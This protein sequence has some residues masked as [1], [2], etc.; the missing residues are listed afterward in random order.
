MANLKRKATTSLERPVL[1]GFAT[2]SK[3]ANGRV[4]IRFRWKRLLF[5]TF[6]MFVTGWITVAAALYAHFKYRGEFDEVS[7]SDMLVLPFTLNEHR[8]KMGNFQVDKGLEEI[9][10]GNVRD[11]LRLLRLGVVRSPG[12]LKGRIAIAEIFE[13]ALKRHDKSSQL[14]IEGLEHGGID[15]TDYL[16]TTIRLLLRHQ[17][18]KAIQD[19][20][21]EHLPPEPELTEKNRIIAFGAAQANSLRGNFDR[22][23]DYLIDYK[24][25]DSLEGLLL[26]A[27]I[28]WDRGNQR[29][30]ISKMENS[31]GRYPGAEALYMQLSRYHRELGDIDQA[32]RY[33]ILRNV[34]DPMS[35]APRLELLYI[36]NASEDTDR[37]LRETRR[38]LRQFRDDE[39]ALQALANFAADSGNI[40]LARRTYEEALESEFSIDAFALLLVEAHLVKEDFP[41]AL[42]FCEELLKEQP[43]WLKDRWAIFQSLRSV[44]SYGSNRPDLGEIYLQDFV[45]EKS[46]Q[47]NTFLAVA[48]RFQGINRDQQARKILATA[49]ESAPTNQKVLS[50]LIRVELKLANTDKLNR[51][52]SRFLQMRRPQISLLEEAYQRLGSDQFIFTADRES[53]LLELG[54][55]VRESPNSTLTNK[56]SGKI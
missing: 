19:I 25:I 34:S 42:E 52:L 54:A 15:D 50:E 41:G 35:A 32:R 16:K 37:E 20:A 33:A 1:F 23:D 10:L 8:V 45:S 2:Q 17:M 36:Y 40:D 55:M 4:L 12:N 24:L 27:Q 21:E 56:V 53:L 14:L 11:G 48:N 22:A 7:Y 13:I 28:S 44:A 6:L 26:S 5:A 47:P 18:D 38:M 3:Q 9:K 49:Y 31:I 39:L 46:V 29:G 51:L 30:A 43:S